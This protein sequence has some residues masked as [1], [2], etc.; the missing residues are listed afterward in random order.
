MCFSK[1]TVCSLRRAE[2]ASCLAAV[3]WASLAIGTSRAAES[4]SLYQRQTDVVYA[5][6]HGVGLLMDI[7]APTGEKNGRAIVDA[8]REPRIAP[9]HQRITRYW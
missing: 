9:D 7:F 8:R 1:Y 5:E 3:L 2:A 6:A 4:A